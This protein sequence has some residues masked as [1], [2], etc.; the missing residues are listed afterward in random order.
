M[1]ILATG[2]ELESQYPDLQEQMFRLRKQVFF[3][4]MG[5]D[6]EIANGKEFD[7][8]DRPSTVY[9]LGFHDGKLAGC[10]RFIQTT[11]PYMLPVVFPELMWPVPSDK[12]TWESSRYAV[13]V[14]DP[15]ARE[16]LMGRMF[17]AVC[18]FAFTNS[19]RTVV[20]VHEP[21]IDRIAHMSYGQPGYVSPTI[22][23]GKASAH[24]VVY[25][26]AWQTAYDETIRRY[27]LEAPMAD[28]FRLSFLPQIGMQVA[29]E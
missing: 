15:E 10:Q 1:I 22:R 24:A 29:A 23:F 19:V 20:S 21:S 6:V 18:E 26:P 16:L 2:A 11:E 8:F 4:H 17:C 14:R 9:V 25:S 27:K 28:R 7:R 12:F 3:D 13:N 5:W